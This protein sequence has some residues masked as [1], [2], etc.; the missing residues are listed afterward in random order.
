MQS[1]H[2]QI[3]LILTDEADN[4]F[5]SL[6]IHKMSVKLDLLALCHGTRRS[7]QLHVKVAAILIK[8]YE[9]S[10]VRD[11]GERRVRG[12]TCHHGNRMKPGSETFSEPDRGDQR[13]TRLWRFVIGYCNVLVHL[14][15][16]GFA[17]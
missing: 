1:D 16:S 17:G 15:S 14:F 9:K 11:G 6:S 2:Q 12:K 8:G 3:D 13:P 4:S 10:W 5:N 7:Q